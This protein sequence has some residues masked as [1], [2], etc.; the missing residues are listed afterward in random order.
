MISFILQ[1]TGETVSLEKGEMIGK[2][3]FSNVFS[4]K[5]KKKETNLVCK[6]IKLHHPNYI[7]LFSPQRYL[8]SYRLYVATNELKQLQSL[9][10]LIGYQQEND[11]FYLIIKKIDGT[12]LGALKHNENTV[13]DDELFYAAFKKLK[14]LHRL[15]YA[16]LDPH[17][18]NFMVSKK[19]ADKLKLSL[20]DFSRTQNVSWIGCFF[21]YMIFVKYLPNASSFFKYYLRERWEHAKKHKIKVTTEFLMYTVMIAL[22]VYGAS[23]LGIEPHMAQQ[24]IHAY[25]IQEIAASAKFARFIGVAPLHVI[26]LC[27]S[28]LAAYSHWIHGPSLLMNEHNGFNPITY[29]N[30]ARLLSQ[31]SKIAETTSEIL[32]DYILPSFVVQKKTDLLFKYVYPTSARWCAKVQNMIFRQNTINNHKPSKKA[33]YQ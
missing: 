33:K 15:G 17:M 9:G 3:S 27:F 31:I 25:V 12:V 16:H 20:F 30:C 18:D 24:I 19:Q 21:D 11:I 13:N 1:S 29:F 23:S 7:C 5:N 2:G 28:S 8:P 4:L 6:E 14:K 26:S 22:S 32:D 10:L